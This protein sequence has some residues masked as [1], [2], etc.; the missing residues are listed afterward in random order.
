MKENYQRLCSACFEH[1]A[2]TV[3]QLQLCLGR[4][5]NLPRPFAYTFHHAPN[6]IL[7]VARMQAYSN[8]LLPF[9]YGW[10]DNRPHQV[11]L[12][13]E[14]ERKCMW[15]RCEEWT[16]RCWVSRWPVVG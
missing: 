14:M 16:Y 5:C 6:I 9:W 8:P 12:G 11:S 15:V 1:I 3:I 7:R 10:M 2:L 4:T 13:L